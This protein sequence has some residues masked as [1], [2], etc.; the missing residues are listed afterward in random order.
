MNRCK[1]YVAFIVWFAG[2][3]YIALWPLSA[4]GIGGVG[5]GAAWTLPPTLHLLGLASAGFVSLRIVAMAVRRWRR[6]RA[7]APPLPPDQAAARLR[8][9]RWQAPAGS[10]VV[11]PR[12]QFGLR[13]VRQ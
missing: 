13:G 6:L 3:G 5:F 2:L 4:G 7:A 10:Q 9:P 8:P 11:K 1:D 12:S